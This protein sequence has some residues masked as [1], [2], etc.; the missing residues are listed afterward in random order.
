VNAAAA[1][2]CMFALPAI[3]GA[4]SLVL[5]FVA[6]GIAYWVYGGGLSLM[7]SYCGD[8]YGLKNFGMNYAIVFVGWAL[9]AFMPKLGGRIR[10]MTGSY[11]WAFYIAGILLIIAIL[12][13]LVTKRP[14]YQ[15]T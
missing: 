11:D 14:E 4:K 5:A 10:D 9:G 13:A 6:C 2:I 1:A 15:K 12:I 8:F 3:I 7:P